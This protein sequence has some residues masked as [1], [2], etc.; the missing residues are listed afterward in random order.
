MGVIKGNGGAIQVILDNVFSSNSSSSS[1]PPSK[2]NYRNIII[3]NI[4]ILF[5]RTTSDVVA[6]PA[7]DSAFGLGRRDRQTVD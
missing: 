3:I 5:S 2:H 7:V 1:V 4:A 6:I